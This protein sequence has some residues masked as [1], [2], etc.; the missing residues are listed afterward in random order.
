M[1]LLIE[2][3]N[4]HLNYSKEVISINTDEV[5][6]V[7]PLAKDR[8]VINMSDKTLVFVAK[9]V[10]EVNELLVNGPEFFNQEWLRQSKLRRGGIAASMIQAEMV[11]EA[12]GYDPFAMSEAERMERDKKFWNASEKRMNEAISRDQAD[13]PAQFTLGMLIDALKK[14]KSKCEE[15]PKVYFDFCNTFPVEIWSYR[16]DYSQ[17]ALSWSTHESQFKNESLFVEDLIKILEA[18]DGNVFQGY[19]GGSYKMDR[20]TLVWVD[21]SGKYTG[22]AIVGVSSANNTIYIKTADESCL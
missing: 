11:D 8:S 9:T 2:V 3:E 13:T 18:A 22:T 19:K 21:N 1:H 10:E 15:T 16:G 20:H 14:E 7:K 12:A 5:V 6:S 4:Q 17:L